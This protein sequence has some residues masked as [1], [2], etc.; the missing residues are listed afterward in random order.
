MARKTTSENGRD[1]RAA[2]DRSCSNADRVSATQPPTLRLTGTRLMTTAQQQR[3]EL[4]IDAPRIGFQHYIPSQV[5]LAQPLRE[6]IARGVQ[7][8]RKEITSLL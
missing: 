8:E 5:D 4:L 6:V 2:D 1:S 3:F 7:I